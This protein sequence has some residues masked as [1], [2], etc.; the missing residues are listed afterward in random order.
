[1]PTVERP[2]VGEAERG[3]W[4]QSYSLHLQRGREGQD[5][6]LTSHPEK[7]Q[8]HCRVCHPQQKAEREAR[9]F[10]FPQRATILSPTYFFPPRLG[11]L[12]Q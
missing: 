12:S 4:L 11:R 6:I 5:S 9:P 7:P 10:P 8:L 3:G 2:Y 1:M